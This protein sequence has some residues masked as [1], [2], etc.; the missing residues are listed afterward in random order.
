[1]TNLRRDLGSLF[2]LL[3]R[4]GL[5]GQGAP[6]NATNQI[7]KVILFMS[8]RNL[9]F[10]I[11]F[12]AFAPLSLRA[13]MGRVVHIE[14]SKLGARDVLDQVAKQTGI[15]IRLPYDDDYGYR[16][17]YDH[18]VS[19]ADIVRETKNYY[20]MYNK[21][22]LRLVPEGPKRYVFVKIVRVSQE[23]QE[24][25]T[26]REEEERQSAEVELAGEGQTV[27]KVRPDRPGKAV[28]PADYLARINR[29]QSK[30]KSPSLP[31]RSTPAVDTKDSMQKAEMELEEP[32]Q[33]EAI[34]FAR[35]QA[36][37]RKE[38]PKAVQEPKTVEPEAISEQDEAELQIKDPE[39]SRFVSD[40]DDSSGSLVEK[41]EDFERK[42]GTGMFDPRKP[43][44]LQVRVIGPSDPPRITKYASSEA[45]EPPVLKTEVLEKSELKPVYIP[46]TRPWWSRALSGLTP[47]KHRDTEALRRNPFAPLR[48]NPFVFSGVFSGFYTPPTLPT[49]LTRTGA[50][51]ANLSYAVQEDDFQD[52]NLKANGSFHSVKLDTRLA[53]GDR[54]D[55]VAE[56]R[57]GGHSGELELPM[58]PMKDLSFSMA[59]PAFGIDYVLGEQPERRR[60]AMAGLRVKMPWG[61]RSEVL[62]SGGYDFGG[63]VSGHRMGEDWEGSAQFGLTLLGNHVML[64]EVSTRNVVASGRLNFD[65]LLLDGLTLHGGYFHSMSPIGDTDYSEKLHED[66]RLLSTGASFRLMGENFRVETAWG[67]SENAPSFSSALTLLI[68]L[69]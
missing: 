8:G 10:L 29:E 13:D 1:M 37:D 36:D 65:L 2:L 53:M 60:G 48:C 40:E 61:S 19:V 41:V 59:D 69:N 57:G 11:L 34:E 66:Y 51:R 17:D 43:E 4:C 32:D 9:I 63:F 18:W 20:K 67:L 26:R 5:K 68:T 7:V 25:A 35:R 31:G 49:V 14:G 28:D 30:D 21:M 56:F 12:L 46:D 33:T 47:W 6:D 64:N 42:T 22:P 16:R 15:V 38:E 45:E 54:M 24:A 27:T 23:E 3:S 52:G 55:V 58:A 62:S 50:V 44:E 39:L